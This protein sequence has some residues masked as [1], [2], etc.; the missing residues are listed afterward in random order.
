MSNSSNSLNIDWPEAGVAC[1][2][3]ITSSSFASH[4]AHLLKLADPFEIDCLNLNKKFYGEY[5]PS[6]SEEEK[7]LGTGMENVRL[8]DLTQD[9]SR[10]DLGNT[11]F[12]SY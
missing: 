7:G 3:G 4:S 11:T 10:T 2:D 8:L 5:T 6:A 9:P 12:P 1:R